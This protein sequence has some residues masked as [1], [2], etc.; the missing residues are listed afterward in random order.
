[1]NPTD[2]QETSMEHKSEIHHRNYYIHIYLGTIS[3]NA[4]SNTVTVSTIYFR[5]Y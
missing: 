1:M 4:N 2:L 3:L 5:T